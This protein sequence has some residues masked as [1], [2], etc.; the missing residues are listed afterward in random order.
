MLHST[1]LTVRLPEPT[2]TP[3]RHDA[4]SSTSGL[5]IHTHIGAKTQTHEKKIEAN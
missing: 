3:G 4:Q 2:Q 1:R 5:Y